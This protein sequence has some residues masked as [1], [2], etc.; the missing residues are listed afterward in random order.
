[1]YY[2]YEVEIK[3]ACFGGCV[4][5]VFILFTWCGLIDVK[6][7]LRVFYSA[8]ST[9][10]R[11][12]MYR[13]FEN[14]YWNLPPRLPQRFGR[15]ARRMDEL[16]RGYRFRRTVTY[17]ISRVRQCQQWALNGSAEQTHNCFN[18]LE[19]RCIDLVTNINLIFDFP[20]TNVHSY[21]YFHPPTP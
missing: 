20:T 13:C 15:L 19:L 17:W 21:F 6:G 8:E 4:W 9:T 5:T 12:W 18:P 10:G 11:C 7:N 2:R 14:N 3:R 16:F 1:M